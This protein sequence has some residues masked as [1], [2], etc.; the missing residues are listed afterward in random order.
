MKMK[1]SHRPFVL[2]YYK[3]NRLDVFLNHLLQFGFLVETEDQRFSHPSWDKQD[4]NSLL[5][6][7][8]VDYKP[9]LCNQPQFFIWHFLNKKIGGFKKK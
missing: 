9:D 1:H 8:R 3:I 7:S 2:R 6:I 5:H 4:V